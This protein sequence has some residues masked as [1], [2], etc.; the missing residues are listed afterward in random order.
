MPPKK[1]VDR[2]TDIWTA[3]IVLC[4]SDQQRLCSRPCSRRAN[5]VLQSICRRAQLQWWESCGGERGARSPT[6]RSRT[7]FS[8]RSALIQM[9]RMTASPLG[10]WPGKS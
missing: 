5:R 6:A 2:E 7:L 1:A 10:S 9:W 3:S 4:V 8:D